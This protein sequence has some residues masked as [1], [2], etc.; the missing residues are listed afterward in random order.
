[1]FLCEIKMQRSQKEPSG[2]IMGAGGVS[3]HPNFQKIYALN[4]RR[5]KK[6]E[7][8][9]FKK[10]TFPLPHKENLYNYATDGVRRKK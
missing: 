7:E 10:L 4:S 8:K 1:M 6:R 5:L 9:I 2:V 3:H